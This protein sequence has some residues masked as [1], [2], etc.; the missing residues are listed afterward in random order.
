M[1]GFVGI[2]DNEW[3]ALLSRQPVIDEV[4]SWQPGAEPDSGDSGRALPMM[5]T[6]GN[7]YYGL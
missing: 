2:T 7:L 6:L 1:K 5:R 4:N 3:C